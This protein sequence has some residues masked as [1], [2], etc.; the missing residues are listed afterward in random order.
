MV[1]EWLTEVENN[2]GG[3]IAI[4]VATPSLA[5]DEM[6]REWLS[7]FFRSSASKTTAMTLLRM[8]NEI[9]M[10][11]ILASIVAPML[12]LQAIGDLVCPLEAGRDLARRI[13]NA[14]FVELDTN[15]HIRYVGC[16]DEVV[17][18][19]QSFLDELPR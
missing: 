16:P 4:D 7:M 6:F 15:D 17:S 5:D 1:E 13:P 19:V 2:W 9:D 10:C 14:K 18:E 11:P 3:P 12:V 8:N